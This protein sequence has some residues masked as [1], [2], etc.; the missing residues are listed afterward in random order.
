MLSRARH[1]VDQNMQRVDAAQVATRDARRPKPL[2]MQLEVQLGEAVWVDGIPAPSQQIAARRFKARH[3][4]MET[5]LRSCVLRV[6]REGE[7]SPR[8]RIRGALKKAGA[9]VPS[10]GE[11][12]RSIRV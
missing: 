6:D 12:I 10:V 9:L 4:D 1:L 5:I 8:F 2:A 3:M 11:E 7:P